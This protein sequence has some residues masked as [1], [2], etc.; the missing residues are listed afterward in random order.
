MA[1]RQF[2]AA[3]AI[4]IPSRG[5]VEGLTP[6]T[7]SQIV[8]VTRWA[9]EHNEVG[10]IMQTQKL[11]PVNSLHVH[12]ADSLKKLESASMCLWC[13][14]SSEEAAP[15][16]IFLQNT[17]TTFSVMETCAQQGSWPRNAENCELVRCLR[18]TESVA[19]G[20]ECNAHSRPASASFRVETPCCQRK[21][22]AARTQQPHRCDP[23]GAA[24]QIGSRRNSGLVV[25]GLL[26]RGRIV[27]PSRASSK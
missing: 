16:R 12:A 20:L 4:G 27:R 15:R 18:S 8:T 9:V 5:D 21:R 3:V 19:L 26:A 23:P 24:S 17:V 1:R 25:S 7:G 10:L 13:R 22:F 6:S 2:P 11:V 14:P